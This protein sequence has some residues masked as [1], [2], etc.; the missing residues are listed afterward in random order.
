MPEHAV[1]ALNELDGVVFQGRLLHVLAARSKR[2][3]KDGAAD[4]MEF[5]CFY[6]TS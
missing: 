2:I 3:P 5:F 4:G 6:Q 1:K